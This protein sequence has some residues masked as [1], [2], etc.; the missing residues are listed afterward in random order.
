MASTTSF[1]EASPGANPGAAGM[2]PPGPPGT[3]AATSIAPNLMIN[4]ILKQAPA[5]DA[6]TAALM[7]YYQHMAEKCW[8]LNSPPGS[9][10]SSTTSN[11]RT[12]SVDIITG[13][14]KTYFFG[15]II[16]IFSCEKSLLV[17]LGVLTPL[18]LGL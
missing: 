7:Y 6:S 10:A 5:G 12:S 13:K 9:D 8:G 18:E 2:P 4:Q 3:L 11:P 15:I 16:S 14:K 17:L 1:H